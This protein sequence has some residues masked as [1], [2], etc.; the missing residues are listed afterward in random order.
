MSNLYTPEFYKDSEVIIHDNGN[1]DIFAGSNFLA[2]NI[3]IFTVVGKTFELSILPSISILLI[4]PFFFTGY[5]SWIIHFKKL[6]ISNIFLY[7]LKY[8][9]EQ[10]LS[11]LLFQKFQC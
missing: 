5:I 10:S 11:S 2:Q 7:E 4:S 3:S 1:V 9:S 6:K 8:P